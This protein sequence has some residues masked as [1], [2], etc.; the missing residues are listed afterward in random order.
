MTMRRRIATTMCLLVALALALIGILGFGGHDSSVFAAAALR[1]IAG[2]WAAPYINQ[3]LE[4]GILT[5]YP[6]GTFLPDNSIS[7]EEFAAVLARAKGLRALASASPYFADVGP[8]SW[9]YGNIQA[10]VEAGILHPADYGGILQPGAAIRRIEIATML[11]RAAGLEDETAKKADL[12]YFSDS[13]PSWAKGYVTVA[14]NHGLVTG[15][16]DAT[17]RCQGQASRAEAGLMVLRLIDPKVRPATWVERYTYQG[18][19]GINTL[20]VVRVNFNHDDVEIRPALAGTTQETAYLAD[21]AGREGAVAAINGGF[22]SAY[23]DNNG[24]YLEPFNALA[25][26]GQWVH[27]Q[28]QGTALGITSDKRVIMDPIRMA[29]SGSTNEGANTWSA[30]SV[31]HTSPDIIGLFTRYR[32]ET[33]N[34][35]DG[36][37]YTVRNGRVVSKGG[38]DV[39]IPDDGYVV[40]V[41]NSR[42]NK[43]TDGMFPIGGTLSYKVTFADH[44]DVAYPNTW[45]WEHIRHAIGCGP[46]LVTEGNVTVNPQAEGYTEAKQTTMSY[47]RSGV[48]V[49]S[50]NIVMLVTCTSLTPQEFGE[51]MAIWGVGTRC[52]WIR[53]HRRA[54]GT[55]G[56]TSLLLAE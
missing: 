49:T 45:D 8:D 14:L 21:I 23:N 22:F 16:E 30:W 55:T 18:K 25:I 1:D 28:Y 19:T 31:N 56:S 3:M 29:I 51:A 7:R 43:W 32:G 6:D 40:F 39:P 47:N 26:D 38:P 37:T 36:V 12:I 27:F 20:R 53:G 46:R 44:K 34:M 11:V 42:V 52:R 48:G 2:H 24:D 13:V 9:S 10:L 33:T 50:D 54:F 15:Y 17:F 5:G 4:K 35:A 41:S